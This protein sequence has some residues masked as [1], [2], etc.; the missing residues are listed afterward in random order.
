MSDAI[1]IQNAFNESYTHMRRSLAPRLFENISDNIKRR[2]TLQFFEIAKIYKKFLGTHEHSYS[3]MNRFLE[4]I[5]TK[6]YPEKKMLAGVVT[7]TSI[8]ALRSDIE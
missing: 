4:T 3:V 7:G 8:E 2:S 6:P 5:D 1:G